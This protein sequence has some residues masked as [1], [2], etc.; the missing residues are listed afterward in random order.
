RLIDCDLE[1]WRHDAIHI[2]VE[3]PQ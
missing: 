1:F 2:S 3:V